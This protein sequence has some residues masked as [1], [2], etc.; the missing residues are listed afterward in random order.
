MSRNALYTQ[1]AVVV[2][3]EYLKEVRITMMRAI[4]EVR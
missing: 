3:I 2:C 4:D 1:T